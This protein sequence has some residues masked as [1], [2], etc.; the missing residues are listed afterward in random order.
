MKD[1]WKDDHLSKEI[2]V[3]SREKILITD[4]DLIEQFSKLIVDDSSD[5]KKDY[6]VPGGDE[7]FLEN[8]ANLHKIFDNIEAEAAKTREVKT[9][10]YNLEDVKVDDSETLRSAY[11]FLEELKKR[12][13]RQTIESQSEIDENYKPTFTKNIS[14]I[15]DEKPRESG[16]NK[17]NTYQLSFS[18]DII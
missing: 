12:N 15:R 14:K 8:T 5:K 18:D 1:V 10:Y 9:T 11:D 17:Q 13:E 4:K 6:V 16:K 7:K 3:I 2:P